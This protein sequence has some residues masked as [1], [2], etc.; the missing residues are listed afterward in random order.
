MAHE[1]QDDD[2][3]RRYLLARLAEDELQ[4]LEE[5]MIADNDF[6]N[7]VLLAEDEMVEEYVHDELSANDRAEFEA[8]FLSTPEGRQQ[9]T[10]AKAL[11]KYVKEASPV[12]E[13][14][15]RESEVKPAWWRRPALVPYL[16]AAVAAIVI[17]VAA[18]IW[19]ITPPSEVSKG[20]KT[21]AYAYRDQ[22]PLEA[23]ITGFNYAPAST[24]RGGEPKVDRTARN[25]AESLLLDAVVRHPNAA[26][27]HAAGR[28]Y[29]AEKKFDEAIEQFEEA[30]K[31]DPNNAQLHSDYGAALLEKGKAERKPDEENK[32]PEEFAQSLAHLN[33]ALSLDPNLHQ[34]LFNRALLHEEM[35]LIENAVADWRSYL[36]QDPNGQWSSEAREHLD[37]LEERRMR[38]Q[39]D[40]RS[41]MDSL[42]SA[43]RARDAERMWGLFRSNRERLT[44]ELI[45]TYLNANLEEGAP[46]DA[47][48]ALSYAGELDVLRVGDRY[49]ADLARFYRSAS[50]RQS[51]LA[52]QA[53]RLMQIGRSFY[54]EPKL[55]DAALAYGKAQKL[56]EQLQDHCGVELATLWLG[57]CYWE[58]TKTVESQR[59]WKGLAQ[60]CQANNHRWLQSRTLVMLSGVA[61][62][63][64]E[65]SNAI[66]ST[67]EGLKL[68]RQVN[69]AWCVLSAS[70]ALIEYYRLLGN[71]T[72]C[73]SQVRCEVPSSDGGAVE[74]IP[75]WRYYDTV[76]TAY[77]T[78]GFYDAAIEY[79]REAL[80]FA[81]AANDYVLLTVSHANLGSMY[82][83]QQNLDAAFVHA[84]QALD[85]SAG[86]IS[87]TTGQLHT[88]LA[89][90]Q[91]AD[92]HCEHGEY[93]AALALYDQAVEL[94]TNN[95]LD[96][97]I[98]LYQAYK[99]R[100][101]CYSALG[102]TVI[103]QNQL[104]VLLKVLEKHRATIFEDENRN[105]F[106]EVEQNIYDIGINLAYS[107]MHD[108][109]QAFRYA[110]AS[111]AR[112]LLDSMTVGIRIIKK[113]GKLDLG[114]RAVAE[115]MEL[116]RIQARI[117]TNARLL[118]Y[119]VLENNL[120]IW[121][122]SRDD[123]HLKLVP[124][125]QSSLIDAV[126]RY[127]NA[128]EPSPRAD[129]ELTA[130]LAREVYSYVI[131]PVE[132]LLGDSRSLYIVPD[133]I[134]N[135]LPWDALVSA[136][137]GRFVVQDYRVTLS[138]S[139][140]MFAVCADLA[141]QKSG[142]RAERIESVGDPSFDQSIFPKLTP[143][144]SAA[145]EAEKIAALYPSSRLLIGKFARKKVIREELVQSDVAHLALHCVINERS[146]MR[147][148]LVLAKEPI[149]GSSAEASDGS[150]EAYEIY[151]LKLPR[152]RLAV[153][154][155]CQT[156]VERYYRG[157]GMIGMA[158]AFLVAQVP[159]VV[160][161]MWPVDSS[162]TTALMVRF[163]T[164]RKHDGL[165]TAEALRLAKCDLLRDPAAKY[166][167]PA[168]WAA[169]QAIGGHADF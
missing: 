103:A 86:H 122:V 2:L 7:R 102:D 75:L 142:A 136:D 3:I 121:V 42:L 120:L 83:K 38:G 112:S 76:A 82:S 46:S 51:D 99:G 26:T 107:Q 124:V 67:S 159:L 108:A 143:L 24:T 97:S 16:A 149:S 50:E 115:P 150:L 71:Q 12:T 31:Q 138:P 14:P 70:S 18:G 130:Q 133:K 151:A 22:R 91:L 25:L 62:K 126:A 144:P 123:F 155:A 44:T 20:S 169:F 162:A 119:A 34:A 116:A 35:M 56:F 80:Q 157:E 59:L 135:R 48:D 166:S 69:D 105:D 41:L 165:P 110:E 100:L 106:F 45:T 17:G 72:L 60:D 163:H 61:F 78:F 4:R 88:A 161:S 92:L 118:C 95:H 147:S 29:L 89:M 37:R 6:F 153:L 139:A 104:E 74:A 134:L 39:Q 15:R 58:L 49:A 154:S 168:Y 132:P 137:S 33:R 113:D 96:F 81:L 131:A 36:E 152:T 19:Q 98:H 55:E 52:R 28:L 10:Y 9:V 79:E 40:H 90:V 63:Y 32:S 101:V 117:P 146:A 68:G 109:E 13:E 156:G 84:N 129:R 5:K 73:L 160:A 8:S 114:L 57:L 64:D 87:E 148:K 66:A 53:Q 43:S 21:L 93:T 158:R 140:T 145:D 125:S 111:R 23:R 65:Y 85:I 127:L 77:S 11:S 27:H 94:H 164:Y 141:E 167:D 128:I 47:L 30:L 1:N 54:N